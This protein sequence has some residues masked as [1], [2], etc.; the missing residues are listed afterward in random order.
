MSAVNADEIEQALDDLFD[1]ALVY[2]GYTDYMRDYEVIVR[3][4]ADPEAGQGHRRYLFRHCPRVTVTSTVGPDVW[5]RS[6]DEALLHQETPH[7]DAVYAWGVRGQALYP[8]A[9]K[10][11]TSRETRRWASRLGVPFYEITLEGNG[12]ELRLMFS[13][14]TVSDLAAGYTPFVVPA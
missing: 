6:L 11:E 3:G 2:H 4:S 7:D 10:P 1:Q 5:A 13:D 9:G 8:G 12:H 14:L